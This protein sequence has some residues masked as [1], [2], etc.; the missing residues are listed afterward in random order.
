[1]TIFNKSLSIIFYKYTHS[2]TR[3]YKREKQVTFVYFEVI[4]TY[5]DII[6]RTQ[7]IR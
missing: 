4:V 3:L 7:N 2:H 5:M 6:C 1:M